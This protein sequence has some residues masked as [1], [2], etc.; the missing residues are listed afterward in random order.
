M[1]IIF[2]SVRSFVEQIGRRR[3]Y[4]IGE[5]DQM[6]CIYAGPTA[7]VDQFLPQKNSSHPIYKLMFVESSDITNQQATIS[8]V[9][10]NYS[11]VINS[12]GQTTYK[13]SPL[14][15]E[16]SISGSRDFDVA[17]QSVYS[18]GYV[19]GASGQGPPG[20][21]G[22]GYATLYN[23]GVQTRTVRYV[24]HACVVRY[25]M[26]P[27]PSP[28][29]PNF[30]SLGLSRV[31]WTILST[32]LGTIKMIGPGGYLQ[33]YINALLPTLLQQVPPLFAAY[34]GMSCKQRAGSWYDVEEQ[35]GP[36]F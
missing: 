29:S 4:K 13:T 33:S 27:Q 7:L 26:T 8:E 35:Y 6:T 3:T 24:G 36:T 31:K 28:N 14:L 25:Q 10:V 19:A 12:G 21:L 11:G 23:L 1:A 18:T 30:S 32:T 16:S 34:M 22:V 20:T 15:I 17:V 9:T 2:S 5:L